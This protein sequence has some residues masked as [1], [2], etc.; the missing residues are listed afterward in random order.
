MAQIC[1]GM[2]AYNTCYAVLAGLCN[3]SVSRLKNTWAIMP[4]EVINI[5][6]DLQ[7][8]FDVSRNYLTYRTLLLDSLPP[9][10]PILV[11]YPKDL[12]GIEENV[13]TITEEGLIS[14]SK[15]RRIYEIIRPLQEY[16]SAK[17]YSIQVDRTV[18]RFLLH[19]LHI[20][21]DL[22]SQSLIC[23]PKPPKTT[24]NV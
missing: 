9:L 7:R 13:S 15:L 2:N 14:I 10:I 22:H 24:T 11:F 23:E 12:F 18:N 17:N 6:N 1:L 5:Y 19:N 3:S 21:D 4:K 8:T 20:I 16:Q